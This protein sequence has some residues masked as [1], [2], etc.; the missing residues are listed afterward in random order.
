MYDRQNN[1]ITDL[2]KQTDNLKISIN[3]NLIIKNRFKFG[4]FVYDKKLIFDLQ[5]NKFAINNTFKN[6]PLGFLRFNYI[7]L[8][9]NNFN[10]SELF[11]ETANGGKRLEKFKINDLQFDHGEHVSSLC[12]ATNGLG[13]TSGITVIGDNKKI[14]ISNDDSKIKFNFTDSNEKITKKTSLDFITLVWS[15]TIPQNHM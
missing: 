2:S 9:P 14:E 7:T 10:F 11:Y 4:K 3:E 15:M 12:S 6:F 5:K 1:K 13:S 8:N